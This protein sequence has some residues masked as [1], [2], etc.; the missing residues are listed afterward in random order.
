MKLLEATNK[1]GEVARIM[2]AGYSTEVKRNEDGTYFARIVEFPGCMTEG[3]TRDEALANLDDAM[4][5]WI[6]VKLEDNEPIPP[7]STDDQYSG[8]FVVRMPKSVH[9][10]LSQRAD[11]E[12]ISLNTMVVSALSRCVG[13]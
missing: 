9:R 7:P 5:G 10:E 11:R 12:G 3:N 8:R 2:D 6:E 13:R 1:A 4:R